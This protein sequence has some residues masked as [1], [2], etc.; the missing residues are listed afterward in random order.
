MIKVRAKVS[1]HEVVICQGYT[2]KAND[3]KGGYVEARR[4]K[5]QIVQGTS[6]E[7]R[8]YSS[9]SGGTAVELM[10]INPEVFDSFKVGGKYYVDFTPAEE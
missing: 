5:M 9:I 10:T 4:F 6:E 1:C 7:D 2:N 3:N 8:L